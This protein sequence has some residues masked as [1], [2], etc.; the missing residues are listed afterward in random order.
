MKFSQLLF[1][2]QED[3]D[4]DEERQEEEESDQV[5][6]MQFNWLSIRIKHLI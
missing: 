5:V 6:D 3:S 2:L 4:D 1:D